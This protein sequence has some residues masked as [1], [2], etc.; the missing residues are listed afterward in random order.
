MNLTDTASVASLLSL[1]GLIPI[2]Y[3][4]GLQIRDRRRRQRSQLLRQSTFSTWQIVRPSYEGHMARVED[5]I[6]CQTITSRLAAL[7]CTSSVVDH[8]RAILASANTVLV[9]GPKAN[10]L[11]KDIVDQIKLPIEIDTT[12]APPQIV[13]RNRAQVY[14]SPMDNGEKAD[15]AVFGRVHVSDVPVYLLWGLHGT[16]TIAAAKAFA[17]DELLSNALKKTGG[18]DFVGVL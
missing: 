8:G 14:V 4:A 1:I 2:A 3:N 7:K 11:S 6:A 13:D 17:S 12:K 9:C 16:G 5:V 15:L 18:R 10:A